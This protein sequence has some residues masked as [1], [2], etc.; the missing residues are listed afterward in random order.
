MRYT[1]DLIERSPDDENGQRLS[2]MISAE[3]TYLSNEG[4]GDFMLL[5]VQNAGRTVAVI[6]A[7][8]GDDPSI[9]GGLEAFRD[10]TG[11]NSVDD[12]HLSDGDNLN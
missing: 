1:T 12:L 7:A 6:I 9:K 10:L 11:L 3:L 4:L 5:P 2:N 8:R